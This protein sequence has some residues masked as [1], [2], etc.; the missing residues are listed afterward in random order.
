MGCLQLL[1]IVWLALRA[2]PSTAGLFSLCAISR[3]KMAVFFF[4]CITRACREESSSTFS[5]ATNTPWFGSQLKYRMPWMD[6]L[7]RPMGSS[8]SMPHHAPPAN[9]VGPWNLSTPYF[10]FLSCEEMKRTRLPRSVERIVNLS[11]L[12]SSL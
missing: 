5:T 11:P 10:S 7:F 8:S 6:P 2:L 9:S 4:T 1:T 3:S 12:A